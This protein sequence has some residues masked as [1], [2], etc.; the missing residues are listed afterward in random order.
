MNGIL[1]PSAAEEIKAVNM[2]SIRVRKRVL[3]NSWLAVLLISF[4]AGG[5][6]MGAV[7]E[8]RMELQDVSG[9]E[10]P[11][12]LSGYV[13]FRCDS[14]NERLPFSYHD[15]L[16]AKNVSAKGILL[17]L[18]HLEATGAGGPGHDQTDS[19]EYFFMDALA[20]RAVEVHDSSGTSFGEIVNDIP[21][22]CYQPDRNPLAK[23]EV[24][25]VQ[26]TDGSTWGDLESATGDL[27]NRR[28]TLAALDSLEHTYEQA[29]EDAF[30]EEFDRVDISL[31]WISSLRN[32]CVGSVR[33][34]ECLHQAV[35]RRLNAAQAH[36]LS[37][38]SAAG[39]GTATQH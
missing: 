13:T 28:E 15:D 29:G 37:I 8:R 21:Q 25:F 3:L 23:A 16:S 34:A 33:R 14:N 19:F 39:S 9:K 30:L 6:A 38:G 24:S 27:S 4:F 22:T 17:M 32:G 20:P 31:I 2:V 35:Q 1:R 26:F 10:S 5:K 12:V 18:V 36:Q 7:V 11:V